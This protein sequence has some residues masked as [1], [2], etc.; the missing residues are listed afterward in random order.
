MSRLTAQTHSEWVPFQRPWT[1][2]VLDRAVE[3]LTAAY[4]WVWEETDEAG[5]GQTFYLPLAWDGKSRYLL[6]ASGVYPADG[7]QIEASSTENPAQA[8][9]DLL[10]ELGLRSGAFLAISEG[11]SWFARWDP[12]HQA[13]ERPATAAPRNT[14]G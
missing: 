14:K 10:A 4:G 9:A 2:G 8:R 5:L 3:E 7:I 12:P 13:G 11:E 6:T 1:I